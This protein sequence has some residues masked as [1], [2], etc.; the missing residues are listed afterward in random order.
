M[1]P[2]VSPPFTPRASRRRGSPF[3]GAY[4]PLSV[5]SSAAKGRSQ[6]GT[7][8]SSSRGSA[9]RRG[10]VPSSTASTSLSSRGSSCSAPQGWG[11]RNG[12][13]LGC[14]CNRSP[15]VRASVSP[16]KQASR[17]PRGRWVMLGCCP[18]ALD[19]IFRG[20]CVHVDPCQH[21][22]WLRRGHAA[23]DTAGEGQHPCEHPHPHGAHQGEGRDGPGAALPCQGLKSLLP[24][25]SR[26]RCAQC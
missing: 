16:V 20:D 19:V 26:P 15:V 1:S 12:T 3:W 9:C 4:S 8:P 2:S 14:S 24:S 25:S 6:W 5:F 22:A 17:C 7:W 13:G 10:A 11:L 18:Y 23:A 21:P